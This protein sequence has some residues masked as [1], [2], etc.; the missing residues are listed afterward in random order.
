MK[1]DYDRLHQAEAASHRLASM[2]RQLQQ[3][4]SDERDKRI[5]CENTLEKMR[6]NIKDSSE[7]NNQLQCKC[8]D[9]EKTTIDLKKRYS[10]RFEEL[11]KELKSTQKE[12]YTLAQQVHY[13]KI[14]V[15]LKCIKELFR[16]LNLHSFNIID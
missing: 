4:L 1:F 6:Q 5:E 14:S 10:D 15:F 2:V 16:N 7:R 11:N 12:S 3:T 8:I 9:L 13:K